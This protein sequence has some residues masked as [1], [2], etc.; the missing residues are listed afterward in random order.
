M[1]RSGQQVTTEHG[2]EGDVPRPQAGIS[3][4]LP[5]GLLLVEFKEG[6]HGKEGG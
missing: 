5:A 3:E 2:G 1:H 4:K 6:I